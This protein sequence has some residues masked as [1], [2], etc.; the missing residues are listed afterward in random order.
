MNG[1][2]FTVNERLCP[3][4]KPFDFTKNSTIACGG[5]ARIAFYPETFSQMQTL[6]NKFAE[7]KTPYYVV[8]NLSNVLPADGE[9][10]R[11]IVCTKRMCKVQAEGEFLFAES[12]V[13]SGKLLQSCLKY[14][15]SGAEFLTGIPCTLGG[16]LYMNAGV[17]GNYIA[18]IVESLTVL[19][20][21]K[22]IEMPVKD[23][24]Y[25]YKSSVFMHSGDCI[26]GA[27]LRLCSDS[28]ERILGN[29]KEYAKRREHLPK[30]KSMGCVFKNPPNVSL[31]AGALIEGAGLKGLRI[32]RAVVSN[33]HANFILNEGGATAQEI[34]TLIGV[35]KNAVYA[36][37]KVRLEEEIRYLQ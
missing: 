12:G 1:F 4:V 22:I 27:K 28:K 24:E 2:L 31:S 15:L 23:C 21:G 6:L 5:Y 9:I 30:G 18:K 20:D 34:R 26:L 8:G 33:A 19:H 10:A 14:S 17:A 7:T 13:M 32:G 36:Q 16:A 11:V 3:V 37:Y 25:A 29:I 35:V